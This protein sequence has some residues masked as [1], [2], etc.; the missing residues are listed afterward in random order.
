M[1]LPQ[2]SPA[3]E[4]DHNAFA[5]AADLGVISAVTPVPAAQTF[6]PGRNADT[7]ADDLI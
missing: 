4:G 5:E 1:E 6:T 7:R 3:F 2:E